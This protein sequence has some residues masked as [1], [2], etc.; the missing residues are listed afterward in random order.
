MKK[1][2]SVLIAVFLLCLAG[3]DPNVSTDTSDLHGG[4]YAEISAS[5]F[6]DS[7]LSNS[8]ATSEGRYTNVISNEQ[9]AEINGIIMTNA[10]R[11]ELSEKQIKSI[12]RNFG[13]NGDEVNA[14]VVAL[15]SSGHVC[16]AKKTSDNKVK[17][18]LF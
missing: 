8:L 12:A 18:Y 13:A 5:A 2:F 17:I 1:F 14:I 7:S 3:C 6:S 11:I 9:N 15:Q 16:L 4:S 10:N